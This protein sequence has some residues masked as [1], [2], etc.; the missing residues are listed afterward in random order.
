MCHKFV[1]GKK[2]LHGK[3]KSISLRRQGV[4]AEQKKPKGLGSLNPSDD[5]AEARFYE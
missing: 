2:V 4:P 3:L 5:E 1:R